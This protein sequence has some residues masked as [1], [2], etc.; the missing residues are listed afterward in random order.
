MLKVTWLVNSKTGLELELGN[1]PSAI[2]TTRI[3]S[4]V[5]GGASRSSRRV[6]QRVLCEARVKGELWD[7]RRAIKDR[8]GLGHHGAALERPGPSARVL[9]DLSHRV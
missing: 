3:C 1:E 8:F 5:P 6:V 4:R 2:F 9:R 7:A